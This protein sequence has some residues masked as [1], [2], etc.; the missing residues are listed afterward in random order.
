MSRAKKS[1]FVTADAF[2][3]RFSAKDREAIDARAA[4]LMAEEFTLRDLRK[5]RELTQAQLAETLGL[6]QERVSR[7]EKRTD[8]LLSTL[9]S[10]VQAMGGSL[11]FVVTFPDRDPV[12]LASL[13]D[14]FEP[15]T[16]APPIKRRRKR[17]AAVTHG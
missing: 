17:S 7:L 14:V 15:E 3:S 1:K 10:Y 2:L 13:A 12:S 8:M 4:V 16:P 6:G 9:A 5:A 11:K